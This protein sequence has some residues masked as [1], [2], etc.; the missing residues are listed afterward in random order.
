MENKQYIRGILDE[1][2]IIKEFEST[3]K[4][5]CHNSSDVLGKNWFDV[6][7]D[8]RDYKN[9]MDVFRSLFDK[10]EKTWVTYENDIKCKNGTHILIDFKNSV[11]I[12]DGKKYISFIGTEHYLN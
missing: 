4:V 3:L 12:K 7:I 8:S 1:N 2:A 5:E 6:F 11:E 10:D 9:V